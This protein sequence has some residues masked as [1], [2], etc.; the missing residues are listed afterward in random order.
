MQIFTY[1]NIL[2]SFTG[3]R[4]CP[5]WLWPRKWAQA[6]WRAKQ[7]EIYSSSILVMWTILPHPAGPMGGFSWKPSEAR[8]WIY[9]ISLWFKLQL[10]KRGNFFFRFSFSGL[11]VST[12]YPH[13][14]QSVYL[15]FLSMPFFSPCG[16]LTL[17]LPSTWWWRHPW[18][19][20]P[21]PTVGQGSHEPERTG[22]KSPHNC[23]MSGVTEFHWGESKQIRR[24][25][26]SRSGDAAS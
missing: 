23:F 8:R 13:V 12:I 5:L 14:C 16:C 2:N 10:S 9:T 7:S 26:C 20:Q 1:H 21:S 24:P 19:P 6:R 22:K 3:A 4:S 11:L 17:L 25:L 18:A 15:L